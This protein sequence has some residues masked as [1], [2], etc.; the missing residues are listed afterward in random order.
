MR[1]RSFVCL[2]GVI[3]LCAVGCVPSDL[4]AAVPL[5][6]HEGARLSEGELGAL[7]S[8]GGAF[9]SVGAVECDSL[10][11]LR[12]EAPAPGAD[13]TAQAFG[14]CTRNCLTPGTRCVDD[15]AFTCRDFF[16]AADAAKG[17]RLCAR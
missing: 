5:T 13:L 8:A 1:A 2:S 14:Y 15:A 10:I 17:M 12:T 6:T 11:A 3:S 7:L 9:I 16:A 4:G